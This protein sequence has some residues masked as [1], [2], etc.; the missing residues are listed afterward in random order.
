MGGA[1]R[2]PPPQTTIIQEVVDN[3]WSF[4]NEQKKRNPNLDNPTVSAQ[5]L[6]G[7]AACLFA[8]EPNITEYIGRKLPEK[9]TNLQRADAEASRHQP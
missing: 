5:K 9:Q 4:T 7:S 3:E 6:V 8:N 2:P 1:I